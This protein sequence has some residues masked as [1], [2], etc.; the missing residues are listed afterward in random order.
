MNVH[1]GSNRTDVVI[2]LKGKLIDY[3]LRVEPKN[4]TITLSEDFE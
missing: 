3:R 1:F 4:G 2:D